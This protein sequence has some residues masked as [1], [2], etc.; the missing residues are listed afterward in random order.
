VFVQGRDRRITWISESADY[1]ARNFVGKREEDLVDT[2]DEQAGA[3]AL[4]EKVFA[5]GEPQ[6]GELT[7]G[8]G[9]QA[10]HYRQRLEAIRDG[11]GEVVGILGVSVE[12]T[13]LK[14]EQERNTMLVRELAHR[15]KNLLAV[16]QAIAGETLRSAGAAEFMDRFGARLQAL[17]LLQDLVVSGSRGGV[18]LGQLVRRQL[19]PFAERGK[20]LEI[21][22]PEV[23]LRP[24][25]ANMLGMALHELATNAT[26]YGS[27]SAPE[28]AVLIAWCLEPDTDGALRFHLTWRESGGPPV[29][30]PAQGG[31]GSRVVIDMAAATL[32]G[33][34]ALDYLPDG[35][36][37]Q[38][39][40]P[41]TIVMD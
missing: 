41:A 1:R 20:R 14:S 40:A 15:S 9:E 10:R 22:G 17:A 32:S 21:A 5:T 12:I 4:R 30:K 7:T 39:D 31:F 38:V 29:A 27:L 37:W 25:A 24:E 2:P 8:T 34:V 33:R 18:E 23:R 36:V 28:G 13:T 16:V 26:K 3:I 35:V 19:A 6:Q 11:D